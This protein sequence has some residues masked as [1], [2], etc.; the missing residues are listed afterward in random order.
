MKRIQS[1][2]LWIIDGNVTFEHK[3]CFVILWNIAPECYVSK[4]ELHRSIHLVKSH[5]LSQNIDQEICSNRLRRNIRLYNKYKKILCGMPA[6]N[7]TPCSL[8]TLCSLSLRK[9]FRDVE[10]Y[11]KVELYP[12]YIFKIYETYFGDNV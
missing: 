11:P 7:K 6:F 8:E 4:E 5:L 9:S 12:S 10:K 3:Q 1:H 2:L